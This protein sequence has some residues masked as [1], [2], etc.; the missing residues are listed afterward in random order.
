[1][2]LFHHFKCS[3]GEKMG[4]CKG[5]ECAI[6]N[7][8]KRVKINVVAETTVTTVR[9]PS[10]VFHIACAAVATRGQVFICGL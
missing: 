3:S 9:L 4:I 6:I 5:Y 2:A 10:L 1:M 7:F 8:V